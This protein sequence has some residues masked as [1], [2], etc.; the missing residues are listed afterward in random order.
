MS[1][2]LLSILLKELK[3]I[4]I[5]CSSNVCSG[6]IEMATDQLPKMKAGSSTCPLCGASFNLDNRTLMNL[7]SA[8][9]LLSEKNQQEIEFVIP[10]PDVN[11]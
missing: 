9:Q 2:R 3:T 8:I 7:G 4:R 1:K 10:Q 5:H 11:S 6:V